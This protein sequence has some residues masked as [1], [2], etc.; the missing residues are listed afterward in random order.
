[1]LFLA[2]GPFI[3]GSEEA[4]GANTLLFKPGNLGNCADGI[5]HSVNLFQPEFYF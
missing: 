1:M 5:H 4:D 2:L 3:A